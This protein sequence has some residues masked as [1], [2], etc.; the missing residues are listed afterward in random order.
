MRLR[1][2]IAAG[3]ASMLWFFGAGF[4][5]YQLEAR[6]YAEFATFAQG[7]CEDTRNTSGAPDDKVKDCN[8]DAIASAEPFK[9]KWRDVLFVALAPIFVAWLAIYFGL[10]IARRSRATGD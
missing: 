1:R 10:L 5:Q 7:L 8:A 6:H 2:W 9:V 4:Y 3:L